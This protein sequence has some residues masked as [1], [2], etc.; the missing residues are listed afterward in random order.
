M[1]EELFEKIDELS[2]EYLDLLEDICNVESPTNYKA[3]V[4]AVGEYCASVA[5][6]NGW[7][8]EIF[9]QEV[10]GNSVL[11]TMNA[12]AD[13]APIVFSAHMDT[14]HPLGSF[15]TPATHRDEEKMYGP[16]AT[17]CKGGVAAAL[18]AMRALSEIGFSA[19]PVKLYLQ[20][21]EENNSNGSNKKTVEEMCRAAK[22]AVGF[23]NLEGSVPETAVLTRKGIARYKFTVHGIA[24][25][26]A[27]CA[28]GASAVCEAAHKIIELEKMKDP[29][30]ITCNCV[31]VSGG[32]AP[33]TVP[34]L[35][36]F[37]A[38]IRFANGGELEEARALVYEIAEKCFV[39]GCSTEVKEISLRPAMAKSDK[40]DAF[41]A[42]MNE[43]Y[44]KCS[45]TPLAP[46]FAQGG[47]DAAYI[48]EFGVPCVDSLGPHGDFIHSV[49]EMVRLESVAESAKR[50]AA[51]A[52][53]I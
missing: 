38:D 47:S 30:G 53:Y 33:N 7:D 45:M 3:G 9:R 1:H 14:V 26:S 50:I 35:C 5:R 11:I 37:T 36:E 12:D 17:D 27:R 29:D 10:S 41:L 52:L 8:V 15:G 18:L 24:I 42:R 49:R 46:R 19:R 2:G 32:D 48:T 20:S 28:Y 13:A 39:E 6:K 40:N 16:G 43:I 21:D 22:G 23:I 4:D 34:E 51:V 31:I 44:E 25:H